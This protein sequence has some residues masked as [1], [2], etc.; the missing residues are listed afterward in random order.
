[1]SFVVEVQ[2]PT[3]N[4]TLK[5]LDQSAARLGGGVICY[6][7]TTGKRANDSLNA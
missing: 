3:K 4:L 7:I 2:K 5:D 1:M 6:L